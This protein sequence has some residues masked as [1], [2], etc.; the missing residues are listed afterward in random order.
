MCMGKRWAIQEK[1]ITL[2]SHQTNKNSKRISKNRLH[3]YSQLSTQISLKFNQLRTWFFE[4]KIWKVG[5]ILAK[6]GWTWLSVQRKRVPMYQTRESN[7]R[8]IK[9]KERGNARTR[10]AVE[11]KYRIRERSQF[12]LKYFLLWFWNL[13]LIYPPV[14]SNIWRPFES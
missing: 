9:E 8:Q 1:K 3:Q 12:R 5:S 2:P 10:A 6:S 13:L 4:K 11:E 14:R 7:R